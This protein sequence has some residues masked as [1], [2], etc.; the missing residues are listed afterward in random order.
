MKKSIYIILLTVFTCL[1]ILALIILFSWYKENKKN[2][3]IVDNV[4]KY[5]NINKDENNEE[6]K[7]KKDKNNEDKKYLDTKILEENQDTV[8]WIKIEGTK[9][10]YPIVKYTDNE[11]YLK[12][13]FKKNLN[14]AGWIF[15]DY[16]NNF[17]DQNIVLYGHNRKDG[18]M[19][20][21][22][23]M[24]FDDE[25]YKEHNNEILF[26]KENEIIRYSIF[27]VYKVVNT[28]PYN[29]TNFISLEEKVKEFK[30]RS[31][32][33]FD[34]N[35]SDVSQIIT[36]STCDYNNSYRLVVHGYKKLS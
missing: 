34:F 25:F 15:M 12:H 9:I 30:N 29:S 17:N 27:S 8:G 7:A 26:I 20:G 23:K 28:D 3:E 4:K 22:L 10:D 31:S 14:S 11:Y 21:S 13:D 24:L 33:H 16:Q 32:I 19:F 18:S 36:L 5:I 2:Q 1:M 35:V 6:K